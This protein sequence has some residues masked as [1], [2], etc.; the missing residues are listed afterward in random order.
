M[1]PFP[2]S[3]IYDTTPRQGLNS[4]IFPHLPSCFSAGLF[5]TSL[6][7]LCCQD[8]GTFCFFPKATGIHCSPGEHLSPPVPPRGPWRATDACL[9]VKGEQSGAQS[10]WY[11]WFLAWVWQR[12]FQASVEQWGEGAQDGGRDRGLCAPEKGLIEAGTGIC[13]SQRGRGATARTAAGI[14]LPAPSKRGW[15]VLSPVLVVCSP[16]PLVARQVGAFDHAPLLQV[17][18][19]NSPHQHPWFP[20]SWFQGYRLVS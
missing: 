13:G 2:Q 5:F 8:L 6:D 18:L 16:D 17:V 19:Q 4:T 11:P 15:A 12:S 1:S 10:E 20:A 9:G 14:V 3:M 7:S